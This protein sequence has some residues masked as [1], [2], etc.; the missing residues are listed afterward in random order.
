VLPAVYVSQRVL[1]EIDSWK[2]AG[3]SVDDVLDR[4]RLTC[5]PPGYTPMPWSAGMHSCNGHTHTLLHE[6]RVQYGE[7]FHKPKVGENTYL[8]L[9]VYYT[10]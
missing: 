1:E 5:V 10:L 6:L 4:L 2:R 8:V 7:I 9:R 3:A